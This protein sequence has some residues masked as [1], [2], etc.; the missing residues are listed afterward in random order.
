[1]SADAEILKIPPYIKVK[2]VKVYFGW[3]RDKVWNLLATRSIRGSKHGK[4]WLISSKSI[5]KLL[6][7]CQNTGGDDSE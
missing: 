7:R 5:L 3:N 1:M 6:K 2:D 4:E